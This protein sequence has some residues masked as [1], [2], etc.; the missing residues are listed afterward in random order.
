MPVSQEQG[1]HSGNLSVWGTWPSQHTAGQAWVGSV[2]WGHLHRLSPR[3]L[4]HLRAPGWSPCW[5]K[6]YSPV[7]F[8]AGS[9]VHGGI[10]GC[11]QDQRG[12]TAE[13]ARPLP[14]TLTLSPGVSCQRL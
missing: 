1:C 8:G 4:S 6:H 5:D 7:Q 9:S 3:C 2:P 11:A 10:L 13:Y 12:P 14:C